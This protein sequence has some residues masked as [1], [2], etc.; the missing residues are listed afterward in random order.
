MSDDPTDEADPFDDLA[1]DVPDGDPFAGLGPDHGDLEADHGDLDLETGADDTADGRQLDEH[2]FEEPVGGPQTAEA[3]EQR[4]STETNPFADL[5]DQFED[6]PFEGGDWD[7]SGTDDAVWEELSPEAE[8]DTE[9]DDGRRISAVDKHSFCEQCRYFTDPP[10]IACTHEGTE[11]LTFLD[12]DTVRVADCPIVEERERL[13]RG[14]FQ[15]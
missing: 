12:V 8:I 14:G 9:E 7:G 11:I 3:D 1:D 2:P 5:A 6:D 13:E 15:K 4:P 10:E